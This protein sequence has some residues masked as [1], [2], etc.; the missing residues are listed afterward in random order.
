M[1]YN[2][3][4]QFTLAMKGA[5]R[6]VNPK[7]FERE[8]GLALLEN[9][10]LISLGK[11]ALAAKRAKGGETAYFNVNCHINL[12]NICMSGCKFCAFSCKSGERG[13]YLMSPQGAVSAAK[14]GP[15]DMTELHVVSGLHPD[16]DFDYYLS[17]IR[18]LRC[19][20]PLIHIKAFTAVEI[21]H[22]SKIS[23]L[24]LSDVLIALKE[25]GVDSLPGGGAEVFSPRVRAKL[26]PNKA[27]GTEWLD[28]MGAAHKL[29][30]KSN[31][32]MLFG[33]IETDEERIDHLIALRELQDQASGFNA[34]IPLPFQPENTGLDHLMKPSA[35][36]TLRMIA[37]SRLMLD[38]F[39][40]I[41][42]Y[43]IMLG[44]PLAQMALTFGAD[45]IDGTVTEER[46]AHAAGASSSKSVT[47]EELI[48]L[49]RAVGLKPVERDSLYNVIKTYD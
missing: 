14:A 36:E 10:D 27:S 18:A 33:H 21:V 9:D 49:V 25:A 26:C 6:T 17:V 22:F 24:S 44:L 11:L 46:I 19:E 4:D 38:N 13:A 30:L 43:W 2:I 20:F 12:T 7:R 34:F 45:D 3:T 31:A 48:E 41:K 16:M 1:C 5:M 47:K 40:H 8:E 28:V 15:S 39:D 42:A 32:T 35:V 37:V 23:N 29:G